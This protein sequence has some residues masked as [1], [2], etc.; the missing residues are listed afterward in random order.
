MSTMVDQDLKLGLKEKK[1]G[2]R[3]EIYLG[4]F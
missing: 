3:E 1:A 2:N 4:A